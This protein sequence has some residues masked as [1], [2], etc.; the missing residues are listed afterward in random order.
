MSSTIA[1]L[2]G[3]GA[4][5]A[6]AVRQL[7]AWGAPDVIVAGRNE[8]RARQLAHSLG[9]A[10]RARAVDLDD[11]VALTGLCAESDVVLNCAGPSCAV[12]DRVARSALAAGAHYVDV[13]GDDPVY[14][15]L[16]GEDP[17][18]GTWSTAAVLSAGMLPGLTGVLPRALAADGFAETTA[19]AGWVGGLDRFTMVAATDFVASL[20]NGFGRS[21]T[22]WRNGRAVPAPATVGEVTVPFFTGPVRVHAYL[23]TETERVVRRLGLR[24]ATVANVFVGDRARAALTRAA[25]QADGDDAVRA[26]VEASTLDVFGRTTFQRLV[27]QLDGHGT[28]GGT[29]RRTLVLS[30]TGASALTGAMAAATTLAVATG[31]VPPGPAFAAEVLDPGATVERLRTADAVVTLEILDGGTGDE[32]AGAL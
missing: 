17:D 11:P 27:F 5:G 10:V 13:G 3:Y 29:R 6:V 19:L 23:S 12:L 32:E 14:R 28:D 25:G 22:M 16:G 4:V 20:R 1:V 24:E 15:L 7:A 8:A 26:L 9:G 30:G 21:L 18:G 2:G 31:S